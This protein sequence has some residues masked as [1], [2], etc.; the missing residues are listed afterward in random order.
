VV[1]GPSDAPKSELAQGTRALPLY[2]KRDPEFDHRAAFQRTRNGKAQFTSVQLLG[3]DGTVLTDVKYGQEVTLRMCI[4]V[5]KHIPGELCH[6]YHIRNHKGVDVVYSDSAIE[7]RSIFGA[8]EGDCFVVEWRF[9]TKLQHGVYTLVTVLSLPIDLSQALV[10][11][12][13]LVPMAHVFQMHMRPEAHLHGAVHW[14][15]KVQLYCT[16]SQQEETAI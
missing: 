3:N 1:P 5:L 9:T 6:G 15:N 2:F 12:C 13:D 16:S 11:F 10:E 7:G 14:E 8:Q 4:E